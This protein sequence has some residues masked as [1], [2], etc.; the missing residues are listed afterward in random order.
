VRWLAGCGP[1]LSGDGSRRI[2]SSTSAPEG[3]NKAVLDRWF[4]QPDA[5]N[6]GKFVSDGVA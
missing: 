3:S 4:R 5:V 2:A 6:V 1:Q